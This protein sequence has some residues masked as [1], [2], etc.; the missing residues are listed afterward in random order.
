[1]PAVDGLKDL[2]RAVGQALPGAA[3]S[4]VERDS[5]E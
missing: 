2:I 5:L 3:V 1:L 4:L